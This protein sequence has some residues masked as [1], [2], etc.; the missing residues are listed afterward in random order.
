MTLK[1]CPFCGGEPAKNTIKY[2]ARAVREQGW[3]Q[4]T[5]HGVNCIAC[6]AHTSSIVGFKTEADAAEAWNRRV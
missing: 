4:D 3:K 2:G 5:F 1:A 6:G